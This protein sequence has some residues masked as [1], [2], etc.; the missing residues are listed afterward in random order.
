MT[1]T[2]VAP[3]VRKPAPVWDVV[4]T[5]VLIL[6]SVTVAFILV[7]LG[8]VLSF[9][10]SDGAGYTQQDVGIFIAVLGPPA[11][12]VITIVIGIVRLVQRRLAFIAPAIG[13]VASG[14]IWAVG[15]VLFQIGTN[16]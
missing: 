13:I 5:I 16:Y 9:G 1:E 2:L 14:L 10:S 4:L 6:T 15:F 3:A 12:S 7:I 11:V 8:A